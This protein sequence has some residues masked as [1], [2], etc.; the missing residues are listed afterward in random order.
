[1]PP[2]EVEDRDADF[3]DLRVA[4]FFTVVLRGALVARRGVA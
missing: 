1:V 2:R 4:A 3:A